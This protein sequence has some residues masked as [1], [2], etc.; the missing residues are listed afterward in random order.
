MTGTVANPSPIIAEMEAQ[1]AT[2]HRPTHT[3][4]DDFFDRKKNVELKKKSFPLPISDIDKRYDRVA[5]WIRNG[6]RIRITIGIGVR[7][8]F[9]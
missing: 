5:D 1:L 6:A 2:D 3:T 8:G 4:M 7:P 9:R